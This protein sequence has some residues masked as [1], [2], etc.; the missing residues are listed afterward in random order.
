MAVCS[1]LANAIG[2]VPGEIRHFLERGAWEDVRWFEGGESFQWVTRIV[3][4][5]VG[6]M[7]PRRRFRA[8]RNDEAREM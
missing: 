8:F 2:L 4:D 5:H 7:E 6:H 3:R 1:R